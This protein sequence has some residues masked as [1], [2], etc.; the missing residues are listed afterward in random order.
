MTP[1]DNALLKNL[2][3][4]SDGLLGA[5]AD[6]WIVELLSSSIKR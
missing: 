1:N 2:K 5:V 4:A 6:L 3:Q